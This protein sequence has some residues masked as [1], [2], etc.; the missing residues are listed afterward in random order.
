MLCCGAR[1]FLLIN[2]KLQLTTTQLPFIAIGHGS[3]LWPISTTTQVPEQYYCQ[4]NNHHILC[5]SYFWQLYNLAIVFQSVVPVACA[6]DLYAARRNILH[7]S[8][9]LLPGTVTTDCGPK[10]Q[11]TRLSH[12]SW[13]CYFWLHID[14]DPWYPCSRCLMHLCRNYL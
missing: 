11:L 6:I 14:I 7:Y 9:Y 2:Y 1:R 3:L 8:G 5:K 12:S 10:P 13:K 4:L